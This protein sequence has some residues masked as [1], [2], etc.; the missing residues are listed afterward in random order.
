LQEG[1]AQCRRKDAHTVVEGWE[2][3]LKEGEENRIG[4]EEEET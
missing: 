2:E 3:E 4:T 1:W